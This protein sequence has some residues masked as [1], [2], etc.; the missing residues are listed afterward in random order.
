MGQNQWIP[1]KIVAKGSDFAAGYHDA[2]YGTDHEAKVRDR[3]QYVSGLNAGVDRRAELLLDLR[4]YAAPAAEDED[5]E[6]DVN[7]ERGEMA[8]P[9][10]DTMYLAVI[11]TQGIGE[12]RLVYYGPD[13]EQA[14]VGLLREM[15]WT[16]RKRRWEEEDEYEWDDLESMIS[17]LE[18]K[19]SGEFEGE[20]ANLSWLIQEI[21][22][23]DYEDERTASTRIA[24][25]WENKD[26]REQMV[27]ETDEGPKVVD[28]E[29]ND[30]G[31]YQWRAWDSD[32]E[33]DVEVVEEG[34]ASEEEAKRNAEE[35]AMQV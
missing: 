6:G 32:Q 25:Q 13:W 17:D 24:E 31:S 2:L 3:D 19:E 9:A 10:V 30:D 5:V 7:D 1:Q 23:D 22:A 21:D 34:H 15:A 20:F 29:Q 16:M 35:W 33:D 8:G 26:D 18:G 27:V 11:T 14:K 4:H 28:V 12:N